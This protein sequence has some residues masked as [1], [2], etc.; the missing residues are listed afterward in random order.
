M[1]KFD[2]NIEALLQFGLDVAAG[3]DKGRACRGPDFVVGLGGLLRARGKNGEIN[4]AKAN[5]PVDV[6][7]AAIHEEFAQ[8]FAD[9]GDGRGVRRTEVYEEN[10]FQNV[11]WVR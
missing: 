5:E 1:A 4:D 3:D 8:V 6:Q 9:V 11:K 10:A 2:G 7:H